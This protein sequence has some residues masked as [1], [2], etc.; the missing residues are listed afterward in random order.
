MKR[1]GIGLIHLYRIVFFWLPSSCRYEP[2][3][4]ATPSRR[5]SA[6]GCCRA[7]GWAPSGSRAATRGIPEAMTLSAERLTSRPASPSGRSRRC[8]RSASCLAG[9]RWRC[10]ARRRPI[11]IACADG[12]ATPAPGSS[13]GTPTPRYRRHAACAGT[14]PAAR[15]GRPQPPCPLPAPTPR[16]RH[17]RA[18]ARAGATPAPA[19]P[20]PTL[21][22]QPLCP[23][24]PSGDP[25]EPA[26][27]AVHPIFQ[28]L[29]LGL[30][31]LLQPHRRHRHRDH[32]AD[33]RHQDSCSS[34]SSARRS[35]RSGGC[36]CSSPRCGRSSTKYKGNRAKISEEQMRL[37]KERGVNP[38]SGCLPALLQLFLLLP[39]YRSSARASRRR[40]S[41]RCSRSS[42]ARSCTDFTCQRPGQPARSRASTRSMPLAGPDHARAPGRPA[43]H[44][45]RDLPMVLPGCSGCQ[46]AGARSRPSSS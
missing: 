35:C 3:A 4:R 36:R 33:A 44:P 39:M 10:A 46:R 27:L 1:L 6:T 28:T 18:D 26:G 23:A 22:P 45:A 14:R 40:T 24:V 16:L 30:A 19:T 43:R 42:A 11:A 37:Y 25:V 29:F 13:A 9:H 31:L 12:R 7:A 17:A 34:R 32:R 5:S 41:A 20:A 2:A 15:T 8:S 21:A 38:A